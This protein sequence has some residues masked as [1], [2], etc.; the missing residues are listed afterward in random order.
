MKKYR[1]L[2]IIFG[3]FVF[4][5]SAIVYLSTIEPTASFWDCGEFIASAW[6]LEVG[7]PPGAP[8]FMLMARFF[9]LFAGS[10]A[11]Q[12]AK[13]VNAMSG[14][15]SAFTILFLFWTITHLVKRMLIHTDEELTKGNVIL[16][17][18]S[19]LIGAL[20]YTFSDTFW[21]SAVEGEVYASSSLFTA[22][23]FWAILKW[24]NIADTKYANRWLILIAYL[25]GLSIG[26]HLLNLL[27][28]P[29]IVLVY[30]FRK[31]RTTRRGVITAL[32]V[33]GVILGGIMY[34][35][36]PGV[37]KLAQLSEILFVNSFGLPYHSGIIFYTVLIVA[38][39]VWGIY[40]THKNK[41]VIGHTVLTGLTVILIGYSSYAL[42]VIRSNVNPPM[43]QNNPENVFTL[44][45]Y[46]NREQYGDR[47]L[48]HGQ[49][50]N[51]PIDGTKEGKPVY[52]AVDGR[53]EITYR[54]PKYLYDPEYKT[55]LPRMYS[56]D[57][58][59]VDSYMEWARI[60]EKELFQ[61]RRD[62]QGNIVRDNQGN[63]VYDRSN[64]KRSPSF[65]ENMRFFFRYQFNHMYWRY[66]M[67]NFAGRQND[68]QSHSKAEITK[69]NWLSGVDFID[70]AKLGNQENLPRWLKE[71]WARNRYYMLPLL[72]GLLG[73]FVQ[74]RKDNKNFWVVMALFFFTGLAIVIYLNQYPHQPRE[75]DY[76][77]AGSFY[78]FAIW[79]GMGVV[80]LFK[81]ARE[82]TWTLVRKKGFI[83]AAGIA[84][85]ILLEMAI[86]ESL[87]LS[88]SLIYMGVLTLLLIGIMKLAG[89]VIR[90][91]A[92]LA[93]LILLLCLPVPL[94]MG[95]E[96]WDDHDRSG[97]YVAR[98]MAYNYL[99]SCAPD[100]ILFTNGDNDTFPLWYAQE[101]EEI[102]TDVRVVN[103]S[104]LGA[105]WYIEQMERE[106][107]ESDPL[108]MTMTKNEYQHGKRDI[109][110]LV[111]R[112]SE[113]T[114][115]KQAIDFL[116]DDDP[117]TKQLPN[118][119][120]RVDYI[121]SRRFKIP[122]DSAKVIRN[123]TVREEYADQLVD[124]VRFTINNRYITK[125]HM[126]VLDMLA[127]NDWERPVCYAVTVSS[128]NYLNL[129]EYFQTHGLAYRIVPVKH[130]RRDYNQGGIDPEIMFENMVNKF[131]WGGITDPDVYLDENILRML[132]NIRNNFARLAE[133]LIAKNKVDSAIM[134]LDRCIELMPDDRVPYNIFMLPVIQNYYSAGEIEKA[135]EIANILKQNTYENLDYYVSLEEKFTNLLDYEKRL[136]LHVLNELVKY[137]NRHGQSDISKEIQ[138]KMQ[139]YMV[140]LNFAGR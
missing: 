112:I 28:I 119:P 129:G 49:H 31:Y 24:E 40:K 8:V 3:W 18:G 82:I 87:T 126:M 105:A 137:S 104:Y 73:F 78:A 94:I 65:I 5:I 91:D 109:V 100:A 58:Q 50:F 76:A 16:I 96:N 92:V 116:A 61:P 71:N 57:P 101:V 44:L 88:L 42:I 59:H 51:A 106:A 110:Y 6:K 115:L 95:A 30:Y 27:A 29:A 48:L 69:G 53:Y 21:F 85:I 22:I 90:N 7:H 121:P 114:N 25:M 75:R 12:A 113:H 103:L 60:D 32:L 17:L 38:S 135:N 2:N 33:A 37:L 127:T 117:R 98:D 64:P 10:D 86:S 97:R 134:A 102:R 93:S 132:S 55:L 125:N 15:A 120:E 128:E 41:N 63:I 111:D 122:V 70:S 35:I 77:Y 19:G 43:D 20:V 13:T 26:I 67:W 45:S 68:I 74:Y 79:I 46:L 131:K 11:T 130:N 138:E 123:K 52:K 1:S 34:V 83:V 107:Y 89:G 139:E 47:P 84:V 118:V 56:S 9:T 14:L 23:V 72:L 39:L 80:A 36:I 140:L 99:N 133:A 4:L 108:P 62:E 66:F 81:A 136:A 54:R 124:E